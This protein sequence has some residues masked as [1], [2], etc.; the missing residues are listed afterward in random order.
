[1]KHKFRRSP[2]GARYKP[3]GRFKAL[4]IMKKSAVTFLC[5]GFLSGLLFTN[6]SLVAKAQGPSSQELETEIPKEI[7]EYC[8]VVGSE[9]DICPELLESMAYQESRF[10][11]TVRNGKHY[12]LLQ[13]NV[14]VHA[15]RIAKYGWTEE[16]MFDPFKNIMVAADYLSELYELYG[17]ENPIVLSVYS[18][19]WKAVK[20]YKEYG[21]MTSYVE[22]VLER[23]AAYERLHEK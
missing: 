15:D 8:E 22:E 10:I 11:P 18:G 6:Q 3:G 23:S 12:G 21:F 9:Y 16:D 19:N 7:I 13:V 20:A 17:D 14:K 4:A 1:M 5:W 2:G